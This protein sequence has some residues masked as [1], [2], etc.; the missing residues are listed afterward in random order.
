MIL[1]YHKV[2]IVTPTMW[3]IAP[4]VLDEHLTSLSDRTFVHLDDYSSPESQVVITF[5]DA[6]E[7]VHR[8]ALPILTAHNVPFEVF[9]IGNQVGRWNEF[10]TGEPPAKHMNLS[11]L[12]EVSRSGGRLQWH[13]R[14]HPNL[15]DLSDREIEAEMTVPAELRQRFPEPHFNW[16]SYPGGELDGRSLDVARRR[17][18]G[19]VSVF[20][21]TPADRW[22]LNRVEVERETLAAD[23]AVSRQIEKGL[24]SGTRIDDLLL[25]CGRPDA[26]VDETPEWQ[27]WADRE[28]TPDQGRIED[29]LAHVGVRGRV[30]LHVGVGNSGL[31]QRFQASAHAIDGITIQENEVRRSR[32]L[33]LSKYRVIA[34]NKYHSHLASTLG[35]QYDYIID[36]NPTSFCCCRRHLA[37]MLA[38]YSA[39]L[40][41]GGTI[42]TDKVGL[43]WTSPPNDPRWGLTVN[44]WYA[45]AAPFGLTAAPYTDHVVGLRKE[46][47]S[48]ATPAPQTQRVS[49]PT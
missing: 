7:N 49:G 40:T 26:G 21:G 20:Q 8:H 43:G 27:D 2:D 44:E 11:Q 33:G 10:D 29:V 4:A 34:A 39:M 25:W 31:A 22:R 32:L 23:L 9:V 37:A 47:Q 45:L 38:N 14:T 19:A 24:R 17:F 15:P 13:T 41:A 30:L 1:M 6:Y 42:V 18:R 36:N 46:R 3:W 16:F 48:T 5:D 35:R 12:D 28:T